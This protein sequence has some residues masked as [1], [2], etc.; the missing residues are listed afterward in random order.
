MG[1]GLAQAPSRL[2]VGHVRKQKRAEGTA[3]DPEAQRGGGWLKPGAK[4]AEARCRTGGQES[5]PHP[6]AKAG[7]KE[8]PAEAG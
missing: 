1:S 6:P 5:A 8:E 4:H 2:L 3:I 7:G